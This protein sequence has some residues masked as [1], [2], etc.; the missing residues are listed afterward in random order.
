MGKKRIILSL[1]S[2]FWVIFACVSF[3]S[4]IL[5]KNV[6]LTIVSLP[7]NKHLYFQELLQ[8][9]IESAGH[10]IKINLL[11]E[12]SQLRIVKMLDS[13]RIS[14]RWLLQTEK[15]DKK[16]TPVEVGI[17]NALIGHRVLFIP[18]G[19]Q[20]IYSKVKTLQD[21][22]KLGKIGAFGKNW[23]DV[24]VWKA[25]GMEY[26]EQDGEWRTIYKMLSKGN[27][28]IDYFSRGVNEILDEA[29]LHPYLDIEKKLMF[30]Y[31]RDYRFYLS[32]TAS[33]Y[34]KILEDSLQK[35]KESGLMDK[36]VKKYWGS[37]LKILDFYNRT[38]IYLKT[39]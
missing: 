5:A 33:K 24:K 13:N 6:E 37:Q 20:A 39:P 30:I 21:F 7:D 15:R 8:K 23:Y 9:S 4:A 28:G 34:K 32:K 38:K 11:G 14:L 19:Q 12:M 27:R 16:Y 35:A 1:V 29:K 36:L 17:T 10:K 25:N 2:I 3:N 22:K 26:Y 18:K 31:D